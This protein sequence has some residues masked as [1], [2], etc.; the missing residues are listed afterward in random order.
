MRLNRL[1]PLCLLLQLFA[2]P[3]WALTV[4]GGLGLGQ[5]RMSNESTETEGPLAQIWSVEQ[6]FHSRLNLGVEHL[7]S[8]KTDLTTSASFTGLLGDR[9]SVV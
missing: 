8:F 1:A 4:N 2:A 7:R 5:A 9:K 6:A 3:A